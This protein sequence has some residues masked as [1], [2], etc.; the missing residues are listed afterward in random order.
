MER[1]RIDL[2]DE[3]QGWATFK[4]H[5]DY[6]LAKQLKD[7]LRHTEPHLVRV[8]KITETDVTES[9]MKSLA[10]RSQPR[11]QRALGR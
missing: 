1:F 7:A 4:D 5:V 2:K 11:R 10:T 9:A 8:V 3:T 6:D